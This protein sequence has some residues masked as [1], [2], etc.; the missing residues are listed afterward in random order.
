MTKVSYT[1]ITWVNG[2]TPLN[3]NNMNRMEGGIEDAIEAAAVD[4]DVL[5]QYAALGWVD[6]DEE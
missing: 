5:T 4:P 2:E 6:P 1:R 3:A